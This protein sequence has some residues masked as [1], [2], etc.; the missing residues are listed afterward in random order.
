MAKELGFDVPAALMAKERRCR[1]PK[2]NPATSKT[3]TVFDQSN[4]SGTDGFGC[5]R[6]TVEQVRCLRCGRWLTDT[7]SKDRHMG[8]HCAAVTP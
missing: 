2:G 8:A 6:R 7:A 4:A 3:T 1:A 5:D